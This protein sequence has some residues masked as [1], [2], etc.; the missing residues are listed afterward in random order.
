MAISEHPSSLRLSIE[1]WA[2]L[3]ANPHPELAARVVTPD[4]V[5]YCPGDTEP[6]RGVTQYKQR[7]ARV[8]QRFPDLRLE[9]AEHASNGDFLFVRWIARCTG[10]E[11]RL[12]FSGVDRI[13]LR[14]G[15]VK[16]IRTYFDPRQL[17]GFAANQPST[18]V[19]ISQLADV[20]TTP[21]AGVSSHASTKQSTGDR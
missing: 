2:A 19:G 14:D 4:V 9:V 12:T 20:A 5:G 1:H 10:P 8:V 11:G 15:L 7:I 3:W 6:V 17:T 16:E 13:Q 18:P 21:P